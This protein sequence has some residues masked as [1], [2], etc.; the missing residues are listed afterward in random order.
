LRTLAIAALLALPVAMPAADLV[1]RY[2]KDKKAFYPDG[3]NVERETFY[4]AAL[5][6]GQAKRGPVTPLPGEPQI[7]ADYDAAAFCVKSLGVGH[8]VFGVLL[9]RLGRWKEAAL[10]LKRA[11]DDKAPAG[12]W[13]QLGVALHALGRHPEALEAFAKAEGL[14]ADYFKDRPAQAKCRQASREGKAAV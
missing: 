1:G 2:A 8:S 13:G 7:A 5:E 14:D 9:G 4:A 10:F 6:E 12:A 11:A 3:R